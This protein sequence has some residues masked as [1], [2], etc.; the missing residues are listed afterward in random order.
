MNLL[1]GGQRLCADCQVLIWLCRVLVAYILQFSSGSE[2]EER[3]V[4]LSAA[5]PFDQFSLWSRSYL[6]IKL[7][8]TRILMPVLGVL[9]FSLEEKVDGFFL[10]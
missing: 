9:L 10:K 6:P 8:V 3:L 7:P 1:T 2:H 5:Q 4:P